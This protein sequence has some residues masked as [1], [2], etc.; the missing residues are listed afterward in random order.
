MV[1]LLRVAPW[2]APASRQNNSGERI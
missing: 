1:L 2:H